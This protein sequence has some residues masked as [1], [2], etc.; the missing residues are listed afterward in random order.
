M[1]KSKETWMNILAGTALNVFILYLSNTLGELVSLFQLFPL[2]LLYLS[3]GYGA[4]FL[5]L[6]L[7]G[8][9]G[10]FLVNTVSLVYMMVFMIMGAVLLGYLIS[11]KKTFNSLVNAVGLVKLACVIG[12]LLVIYYV[13]KEDPFALIKNQMYAM[14][15]GMQ[16]TLVEDI[17]F[18]DLSKENV[19]LVVKGF[20]ATVDSMIEL[21]P[22]LIFIGSYIVS[23]VNVWL[24]L[25]IFKK[26]A[27]KIPYI[28]KLNLIGDLAE[29]KRASIAIGIGALLVYVF[30]LANAGSIIRNMLLV[31]AFFYLVDGIM[32]LDFIYERA[33]KNW[34]RF[35]IPFI[36]LVLLR[37]HIIYVVIGFVDMLLNFRRRII[38]KDAIFKK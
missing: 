33:K 3:E 16:K 9:A 23:F 8:L 37:G 25:V 2:V 14:V 10:Y 18:S 27:K 26:T 1:F 15:D 7:T 24:T 19:D 29:L 32:V 31:L 6:G 36:L 38:V 12:M 34:S 20:K 4:M 35:L 5:A 22:A 13:G 28:T 21:M 17:N 30:S 11:K